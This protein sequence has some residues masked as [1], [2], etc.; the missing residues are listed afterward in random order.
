[1][2][3]LLVLTGT[4]LFPL[5]YIPRADT[6]LMVE[7]RNFCARRSFHQQKLAFVLGCMRNVRDELIAAGRRVLYFGIDE[8]LSLAEGVQRVVRENNHS[9]LAYFETEDQTPVVQLCSAALDLGLSLQTVPS[10]MFLTDSRYLDEWFATNRPAMSPFYKM[11]RRRLGILVE[12]GEPVGGRWNFDHDNRSKVRQKTLLP[13]GPQATQLSGNSLAAAQDVVRLYPD[14][15]GDSSGLWLPTSRA[16]A[17]RWLDEFL[18]NRFIGFGTY[19]DSMTIRSRVVHHSVISPFLN[20][21]LLTPSDVIDRVLAFARENGVALNDLEGFVR[22]IL[23]WREFIRGMY[24]HAGQQMRT[25]NVWDAEKGLADTWYEAR[26]GIFPLD[27]A[28]NGAIDL[29]WNHHI[30][31]LMVIANLMNLCGIR[32]S[33]VYDYFMR[34]YID[35]YDWVM[36]PNVF[37]MGLGSDGGLFSTKPYISGSNYLR[38]M[39]D[40]GSGPWCETV[41]G[42]FWRFISKHEER[43]RKN[44]RL[45]LIVAQSNRIEATRRKRLYDAA[46]G[47]IEAHTT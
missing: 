44:P 32:P 8:G 6:V 29:A 39:S 1:M 12:G 13:S 27:R 43:L 47:F 16:G 33:V 19:E 3:R 34:Y 38:K 10:P 36:V 5:P 4:T 46:D 11:Q 42:L 45:A 41:D 2:P 7:D 21:G 24:R 31:R 28:L 30:E 17:E 18:Y 15:P 14:H 40:Y 20:V 26:T 25:A 9:S 37:G 23:G 22:Q 35:A